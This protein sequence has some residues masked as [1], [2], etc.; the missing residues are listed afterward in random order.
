[1]G[2]PKAIG[3]DVPNFIMDVPNFVK[4][5]PRVPKCVLRWGSTPNHFLMGFKMKSWTIHVQ[6]GD[7]EAIGSNVPNLMKDVPNFVKDV[8][9][10]VKDVPRVKKCVPK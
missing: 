8:P 1:M 7:L 10:F 5:V 6:M 9:N 4:D 3:W 2:V